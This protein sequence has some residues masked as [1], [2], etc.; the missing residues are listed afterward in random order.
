MADI[1]HVTRPTGKLGIHQRFLRSS[2]CHASNASSTNVTEG[3]FRT[4]RSRHPPT[5][6]HG[7]PVNYVTVKVDLLHNGTLYVQ[8][9]LSYRFLLVLPALSAPGADLTLVLVVALSED[10]VVF[11]TGTVEPLLHQVSAVWQ[12]TFTRKVA[13]TSNII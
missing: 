6:H 7:H 13:A 9:I 5:H 12:R 4:S 1:N 11:A 2:C 10:S 8:A 3:R